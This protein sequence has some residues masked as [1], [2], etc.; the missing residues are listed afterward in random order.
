[1]AK[2]AAPLAALTPIPIV[3]ILS[4]NDASGPVMMRSAVSLFYDLP[5]CPF[6][7]NNIKMLEYEP[8]TKKGVL[9]F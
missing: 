7:I 1:V 8:E 4:L 2:I 9:I 6:A 3:N 5:M